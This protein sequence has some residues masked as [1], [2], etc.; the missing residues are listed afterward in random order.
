MFIKYKNASLSYRV[1]NMIHEEKKMSSYEFFERIQDDNFLQEMQSF[2][3]ALTCS[4]DH[5][6]AIFIDQSPCLIVK[7]L[8]YKKPFDNGPE[9][10][11]YFE[12]LKDTP[13]R[14]N[15]AMLTY[16]N[17][18]E[19]IMPD[20]VIFDRNMQMLLR[21]QEHVRKAGILIE[22]SESLK[23]YLKAC[24]TQGRFEQN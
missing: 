21:D 23:H 18:V 9:L 8:I 13:Y 6:P 15:C 7:K 3:R 19:P 14:A 12:N 17:Y 20:W 16:A 1:I 11:A 2:R 4:R 22:N 24:Q 10:D 5:Q